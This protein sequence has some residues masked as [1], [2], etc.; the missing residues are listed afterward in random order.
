MMV[1]TMSH[2]IAGLI[3]TGM[4]FF[5][6]DELCA[7]ALRSRLQ[8]NLKLISENEQWLLL[9]GDFIREIVMLA[10]EG[11]DSDDVISVSPF[12]MMVCCACLCFFGLVDKR[13]YGF[14]MSL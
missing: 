1:L 13:F 9:N 6:R 3:M 8:L 4:S 10:P 11:V 5:V 7:A 2:C 12:T 14:L